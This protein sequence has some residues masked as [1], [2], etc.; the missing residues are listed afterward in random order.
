MSAARVT[1][2]VCLSTSSKKNVVT[3]FVPPIEP[4]RRCR[5]VRGLAA[6]RFLNTTRG[7]RTRPWVV[8]SSISDAARR[9]R[10]TPA[11]VVAAPLQAQRGAHQHELERRR[12]YVRGLVAQLLFY[13]LPIS[14]C[15]K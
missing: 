1:Y 8:S 5:V 12:R 3:E 13:E 14:Q 11:E 2:F 10:R 4:A 9:T 7:H 15:Y 6:P